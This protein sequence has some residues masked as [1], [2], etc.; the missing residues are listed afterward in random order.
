MRHAACGKELWLSTSNPGIVS[1]SASAL[2]YE[3]GIVIGGYGRHL[4]GLNAQSGAVL[5]RNTQ[6]TVEERTPAED[7]LALPGDGTALIISRLNGLYRHDIKT[8]KALWCY[9]T[10]FANATSVVDGNDVWLIGNSNELIKLNL[11]NCAKIASTRSINC[12]AYSGTPAIAP[13]KMLLVGSA[14]KGLAAVDMATLAEKWRFTPEAALVTTGDYASGNPPSVT[15][16]P[17]VDGNFVWIPA[18]DGYLYKL[19]LSNGTV[20]KKLHIGAPLLTKCAISG[21][22]LYLYDMT[23]RVFAI[24]REF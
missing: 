20:C 3:D 8:G 22:C 1:P 2:A 11:S 16:S 17:L 9:K 5:W 7:R 4:R 24:N 14:Q 10:L 6:W 13:G 21:Q 15:A 19:F 23:G 18:N 12:I